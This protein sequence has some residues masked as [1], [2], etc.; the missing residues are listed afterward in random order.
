MIYRWLDLSRILL[1]SYQKVRVDTRRR[2]ALV[3]C[4]DHRFLNTRSRGKFLYDR[5]KRLEII[6]F[7]SLVYR[8][9][10]VYVRL[11][12]KNG[13]VVSW[14]ACVGRQCVD[15]GWVV[16]GY[17]VAWSSQYCIMFELNCLS[18]SLFRSCIVS[19]NLQTSSRYLPAVSLCVWTPH[20][21]EFCTEI[22][23]SSVSLRWYIV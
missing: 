21:S 20:L 22:S 17:C 10:I 14:S 7:A 5:F 9:G 19:L 1:A 4:L 8:L 11:V 13:L 18:V 16:C 23:S 6:W 12:F 3:K 2:K 15:Y